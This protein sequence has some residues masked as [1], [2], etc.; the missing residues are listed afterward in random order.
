MTFRNILHKDKMDRPGMEF[1]SRHTEP[2]RTDKKALV[3]E[4]RSTGGATWSPNGHRVPSSGYV[5][6]VARF[7]TIIDAAELTERRLN[8][9]ED[10]TAT[11][12]QTSFC[13]AWL[14]RETG[15]VHLDRVEIVEDLAE[16]KL[17]AEL[18]GQIAIFCLTTS[19]EIRM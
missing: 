14:D 11:A 1:E 6:A 7:E 18:E 16:A 2:Q 13:G 9:Y 12:P 15:Y 17:D 3:S 19:T 5:V 8:S 4:I 10:L